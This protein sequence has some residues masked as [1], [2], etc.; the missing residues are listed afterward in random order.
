V[1]RLQDVQWRLDTVIVGQNL[2]ARELRLGLQVME[3]ASGAHCTHSFNIS[4]QQ[5][6][7]LLAGGY[8][9]LRDSLARDDIL[10]LLC[11]IQPEN[12]FTSGRLFCK[13]MSIYDLRCDSLLRYK[14]AGRGF[15][16][17]CAHSVFQQTFPVALF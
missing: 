1:S 10:S 11:G 2:T 13:Y 9:R 15:N 16:I 14:P 4:T 6:H 7:L 12:A 3:P 8:T 17:Q 5:V